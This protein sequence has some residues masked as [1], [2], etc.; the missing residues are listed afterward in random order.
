MYRNVVQPVVVA[1]C[2][3]AGPDCPQSAS[4]YRPNTQYR[5]HHIKHNFCAKF[6]FLILQYVAYC[7]S[8]FH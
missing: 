5:L 3:M 2:E 7:P 8:V 6:V 4:N 1:R